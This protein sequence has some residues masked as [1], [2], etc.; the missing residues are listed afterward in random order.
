MSGGVILVAS[1]AA[2]AIWVILGY[3][4]PAANVRKARVPRS[5]LGMN[6]ARH[7]F[8]KKTSS[9]AAAN[10]EP[11]LPLTCSCPDFTM[12]RTEYRADDPRRLC[13]HL[14]MKLL[15]KGDLPPEFAE[16][17]EEL[18]DE[19]GTPK[20]FYPY[21]HREKTVIAGKNLVI[22]ADDYDENPSQYLVT[23][24]YEGKRYVYE[25]ETGKWQDGRAPR[26]GEE[27]RAWVKDMVPRFQP[28]PLPEGCIRT[29]FRGEG[30][31]AYQLRGEITGHGEHRG[32][33]ASMNHDSATFIVFAGP[34]DSDLCSLE[35]HVMT[36]ERAVA[37]R[38]RYMERAVRR[39]LEDEYPD[40][41]EDYMWG[42]F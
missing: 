2:L 16:Y 6:W 27:I 5:W 38:L 12:Y 14:V 8:L 11:V 32:V 13:R 3:W 37:P 33:R 22:F 35:Y 18:V 15:E 25:P 41:K 28:R 1:I 36:G 20:G 9:D 23:L 34:F 29:I 39:W 26:Y 10:T 42:G 19:E 30:K 21:S 24:F 7:A 4:K 40:P 31:T 17:R